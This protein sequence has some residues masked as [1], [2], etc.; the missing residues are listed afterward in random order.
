MGY[1]P[2]KK[3]CVL[4]NSAPRMG[5]YTELSELPSRCQSSNLTIT[6]LRLASGDIGTLFTWRENGKG[7]LK[8]ESVHLQQLYLVTFKFPELE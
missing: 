7:F 1:S 3:F 4:I 8:V 5:Q 2:K 6:S